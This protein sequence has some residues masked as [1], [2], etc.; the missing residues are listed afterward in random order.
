MDRYRE[1]LASAVGA[2]AFS[3][4][5]R[6]LWQH[7]SQGA[8]PAR[9]RNALS[10]AS[11]RTLTLLALRD[12]LY[13][14]FYCRGRLAE[15][16]GAGA[17]SA[18]VAEAFAS[19]ISEANAGTGSWETGWTCTGR[20]GALYLE[21]GGLTV[22]AAPDDTTIENGPECAPGA[23]VR[24]R[25][26][27]ELPRASPGYYLALGDEEWAESALPVVRVYWNLSPAGAIELMRSATRW[28]NAARIPF[29]LKALHDPGAYTRCDA[30]VLYFHGDDFVAV[31]H[32]L[33]AAH[34]LSPFFGSG[35]PAFTKMLSPGLGLAESPIGGD[36]FGMSR[37]RLLAESLL[38][39]HDAGVTAPRARVAFVEKHLQE[40]GVDI[41]RP[42]LNPGSA[43]RYDLPS[44]GAHPRPATAAR[45][46]GALTP[47][48]LLLAACRI[49]DRLADHAI[50][51]GNR[52]A[53]MGAEPLDPTDSEVVFRHAVL[54][55]D[56][57]EGASGIALFL[58]ELSV[59][60]GSQAFRRLALAAS[61]EALTRAESTAGPETAGLFDGWS[62]AALAGARVG[63]I[64]EDPRLLSRAKSLIQRW[65]SS[66]GPCEPFDLISG[67]AGLALA[68]LALGDL[69]QDKTVREYAVRVGD[70]LLA[71]A[72]TRE[73]TSSWRAPGADGRRNLAGFSHGA[74]GAAYSLLEI[75]QAT[76]E[77][78]FQK[79]AESAIAYEQAHFNPGRGNW[80]DFRKVP[81]GQPRS[82][83]PSHWCHGA[84]GIALARLR[85][86]KLLGCEPYREQA[87]IALE[88]TAR[89]AERRRTSWN[90]DPC[91]CHGLAG[92]AEVLLCGCH[93]APDGRRLAD[94]LAVAIADTLDLFRTEPSSLAGERPLGLMSGLAGIGYLFL[95]LRD[96]RVPSVVMLERERVSTRA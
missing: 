24:V 78:R 4:D 3:R 30:A 96:E 74:S 85:A 15:R 5:G 79:G 56:L 35:V 72:E 90:A 71:T 86:W 76:G 93:E 38:R 81:R 22:N 51:I 19:A 80:A 32:F 25:A 66:G 17:S 75:F 20:G 6:F 42:Y 64:L 31:S 92:D 14:D 9:I 37:C 11:H 70:S 44:A 95:R 57:Y 62:G 52:V 63:W 69:L 46:P 83:Y 27:H 84:P 60:S 34:E 13:R 91:L 36:S 2:V 48:Q 12:T 21:R 73:G 68:L 65:A 43:D 87:S 94:R 41:E 8:L 55:P 53:W 28:L 77:S 82:P 16:L 26:P 47:D 10:P 67:K 33:A 1:Q 45:H 29:R 61:G 39:A 7:S 54:G 23:P 58:A 50:W 49:G 59:A 40:N 18:G 88:T 89:E